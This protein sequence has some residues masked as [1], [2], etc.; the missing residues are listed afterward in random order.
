MEQGGRAQP[1]GGGVEEWGSA[2]REENKAGIGAPP[3]IFLKIKTMQLKIFT[4]P[5]LGGE[6]LIEEMNV[7]LRSKKILQVR[8]RMVSTEAEGSFWC[9]AVRY[10]DD[11]TATDR[12]RVKVD[13]QKVLDAAA[14]KR[15]LGFKLI[16]KQVAQNDAVPPYAVF[17]DSELAEL[18]KLENPTLETMQAVKGVGEKKIEKYGQFFLP[19]NDDETKG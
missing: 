12:E 17:T 7:F 19:K 5:I 11:V 9:F 18:A 6:H 4:I 15:F 13:Y 2:N 10:V 8:E 1:P 3:Q 16:R 14:F